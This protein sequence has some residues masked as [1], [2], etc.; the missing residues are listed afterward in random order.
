MEAIDVAFDLADQFVEHMADSESAIFLCKKFNQGW[1]NETEELA[2]LIFEYQKDHIRAYG[3]PASKEALEYEFKDHE[4]QFE[5]NIVTPVEYLIDKFKERFFSNEAKILVTKF[6]REFDEGNK[7]EAVK[8]LT[9][10]FTNLLTGTA[11]DGVSVSNDQALDILEEYLEYRQDQRSGAYFGYSELDSYFNGIQVG[12]LNVIAARLKEKK[13]WNLLLSAETSRAS[14]LNVVFAAL[15][16]PPKEMYYRWLCV[17]SGVSWDSYIK[18]R[19][20]GSDKE[21][22]R[23]VAKRAE[24]FE[25][26]IHF[27][28]PAIDERKV[29]NIKSLAIDLGADY[30]VLDQLSKI[31]PSRFFG[32]AR[33]LEIVDVMSELK[34]DTCNHFP[35][36]MAAQLNREAAS[37]KEMAA[38]EHLGLSDSVGQESDLVLGLYSNKE[39]KRDE[40]F[41]VGVIAARNYEL[42]GWDV[43]GELKQKTD[44]RVVGTLDEY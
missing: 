17:L 41:Q 28:S 39:M 27:V 8:V 15:D 24:S 4:L 43:K 40:I 2:R 22:L 9:S 16:T 3:E 26:K 31:T 35:I 30:L 25:S 23:K 10:D 11:R 36:L 37:L 7:R 20:S 44:F 21:I 18:G 12:T 38:A 32:S 5:S 42:V 14:G 6:I 29:A 1:I 33:N 19:L 34:A 13:S